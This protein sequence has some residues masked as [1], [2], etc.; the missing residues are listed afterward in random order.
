MSKQESH[1]LEYKI[2]YRPRRMVRDAQYIY[3][4][5]AREAYIKMLLRPFQ[6]AACHISLAGTHISFTYVHAIARSECN[7]TPRD[8]L[9]L[10]ELR[11]LVR[12]KC[13]LPPPSSSLRD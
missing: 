11:P 9:A 7:A 10:V 12:C 1:D 3:H 8:P 6:I 13:N 2:K 4:L 5:Y